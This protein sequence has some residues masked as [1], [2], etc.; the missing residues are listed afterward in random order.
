MKFKQS[1]AKIPPK[2][3]SVM[4][5]LRGPNTL[6]EYL[7]SI[8][9]YPLVFMIDLHFNGDQEFGRLKLTLRIVYTTLL[10]NCAWIFYFKKR[11]IRR[12]ILIN[13]Y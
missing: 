11:I 4:S 2:L 12:P 5:P 13:Q 6:A 10:I 8:V 3:K 9:F 7:Y 1:L